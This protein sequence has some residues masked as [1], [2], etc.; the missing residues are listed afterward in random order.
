MHLGS[1]K[2][3]LEYSGDKM[4]INLQILIIGSAINRMKTRSMIQKQNSMREEDFLKHDP[5]NGLPKEGNSFNWVNL[6]PT[7]TSSST[8]PG[9]MET[10]SPTDSCESSFSILQTNFVLV[11]CNALSSGGWEFLN[12]KPLT[13]NHNQP[14][15]TR[16][17]SQKLHT[18]T[19]GN[20]TMTICNILPGLSRLENS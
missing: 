17:Y 12:Q 19:Y 10:R 3:N 8:S 20:N 11:S 6:C 4:L 16:N 15:S 14:V 13:S 2:T 5:W 7:P 18:K 1:F 9:E